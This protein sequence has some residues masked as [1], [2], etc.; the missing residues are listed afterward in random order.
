VFA[1]LV[2]RCIVQRICS[3]DYRVFYPIIIP[4]ILGT[5]NS[6]YSWVTGEPP[7]I[8]EVKA[9]G[10]VWISSFLFW[11]HFVV[12]IIIEMS[13]QLKIQPF[14]LQYKLKRKNGPKIK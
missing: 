14:S 7:I 10:L 2:S 13:E 9:L 1:Y 12:E 3:E 11:A 8:E 6:V 4:V 5:A